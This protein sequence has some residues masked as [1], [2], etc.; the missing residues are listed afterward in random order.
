MYSACAWI[1][2]L[3]NDLGLFSHIAYLLY[4]LQNFYVI[5]TSST[6]LFCAYAQFQ[7]RDVDYLIIQGLCYPNSLQ[8]ISAHVRKKH[9]ST[10]E[11]RICE[12]NQALENSYNYEFLRIYAEH[13]IVST[14]DLC[15]VISE[16][17]LS[18]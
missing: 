16:D 5:K 1:Y 9:V 18:I 12:N 7:S 6:G 3:Y 13:F 8:G 2:I 17:T 10:K 11:L 4:C 15:C 14:K